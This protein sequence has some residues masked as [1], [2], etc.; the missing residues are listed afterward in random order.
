MTNQEMNADAA[1]AGAGRTLWADAWLRLR[2]SR[3]AMCALAVI[4]GYTALALYGEAVYRRCRL[5]DRTPPYQ[6]PCPGR[7]Y[8]PPGLVRAIAEWRSGPAGA[9]GRC[10][11]ARTGATARSTPS[12]GLIPARRQAWTNFTAPEVLSRSVRASV[13]ISC[14]AA[15]STRTCGWEAP[16]CRE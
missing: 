1:P 9:A 10:R 5:L 11:E 12:T 6:Q 2:R 3:M 8:E 13:S 7:E 4:A 15:R 16:N 14:S